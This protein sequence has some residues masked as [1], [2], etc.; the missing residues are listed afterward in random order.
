MTRIFKSFKD[1]QIG[2]Y[3]QYGTIVYKKDIEEI[4]GRYMYFGEMFNNR[5]PKMRVYLKPQEEIEEI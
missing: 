2:G 4:N 1:I 3:F 5:D